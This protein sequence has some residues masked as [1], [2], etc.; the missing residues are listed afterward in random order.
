MSARAEEVRDE[1]RNQGARHRGTGRR[2]GGG[3][4]WAGGDCQR[5]NSVEEEEEGRGGSREE[6]GTTRNV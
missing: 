4:E 3:R 6:A 5:C 2:Q 1:S